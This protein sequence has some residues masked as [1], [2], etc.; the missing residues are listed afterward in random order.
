MGASADNPGSSQQVA[1]PAQEVAWRRLWE[2]LLA[3]PDDDRRA[4]DNV[5]DKEGM[6]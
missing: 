3:E 1:F 2:I 6:D 4:A 5:T